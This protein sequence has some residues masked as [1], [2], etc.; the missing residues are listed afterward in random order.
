[1]LPVPVAKLIFRHRALCMTKSGWKASLTLSMQCINN[2]E[3]W[4]R[5]N[6]RQKGSG[7]RTVSGGSDVSCPT[8]KPKP[9]QQN[10]EK[11]PKK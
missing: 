6:V 9:R 1:M 2:P 4:I 5:M 7:G 8:L 11:M 10:Y 3:I